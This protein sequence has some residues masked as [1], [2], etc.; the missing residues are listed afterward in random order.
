MCIRDRLQVDRMDF[1]NAYWARLMVVT[2]PC[3]EEGVARKQTIKWEDCLA[4]AS[5][6]QIL[7]TE[8]CTTTTAPT[9]PQNNKIKGF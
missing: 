2:S 9:A 5:E 4:V 8:K 1:V 6:K 3:E 7:R